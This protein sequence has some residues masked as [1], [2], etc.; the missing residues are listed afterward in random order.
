ME[1]FRF[2][3]LFKWVC[4]FLGYFSEFLK[5]Y[6]LFVGNHSDKLQKVT[7]KTFP[8]LPFLN[9]KDGDYFFLISFWKIPRENT[10][11]NKKN[12]N[13]HRRNRDWNRESPQSG[14][15]TVLQKGIGRAVLLWNCQN[16]SDFQAGSGNDRCEGKKMV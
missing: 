15:C 10:N 7:Q 9:R 3:Y 14:N 11:V 13:V 4:F 16:R 6:E 2:I 1:L 12:A 8:I 5:F